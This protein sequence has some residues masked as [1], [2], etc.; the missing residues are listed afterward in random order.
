MTT[1]TIDRICRD[2]D[3]IRNELRAAARQQR[4]ENAPEIA[5]ELDKEADRLT[6]VA[7]NLTCYVAPFVK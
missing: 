4:R 5:T 1:E 6:D 7:D 2:L 3:A